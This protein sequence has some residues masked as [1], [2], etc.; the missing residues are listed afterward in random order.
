MTQ[1]GIETCASCGSTDRLEVPYMLGGVE[2][3]NDCC[4]SCGA[5]WG[6]QR[7]ADQRRARAKAQAIQKAVTRA[8]SAQ[9]EPSPKGFERTSGFHNVLKRGGG[10]KGGPRSRVQQAQPFSSV[11]DHPKV[12]RQWE[13]ER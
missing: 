10:I 8:E 5:T 12:Q 3:R 2:M 1:A 13:G 11:A 7:L 4:G 9:P 6:Y